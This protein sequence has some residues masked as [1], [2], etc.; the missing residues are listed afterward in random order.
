MRE[1]VEKALDTVALGVEG[2]VR[3]ARSVD[4]RAGWDH[5]RGAGTFNRLDGG[6][7]VVPLVG[8]D[9]WR[10]KPCQQ[11]LGLRVVGCLTWRQDE[12]ERIAKTINSRVNVGGQPARRPTKSFRLLSPPFAP[13]AC[14]WARTRVESIITYSKSGSPDRARNTRSQTPAFDHR[15]YRWNTLFHAP[16][17]SGSSRQCAPV[18]A[19]QSTAST[20]FRLS[21]AVR[22]S[23][24][25]TSELQSPKDL[26]CRLLLEK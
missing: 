23:E 6:F 13:A 22:R 3:G 12:A 20:N 24:E 19:I 21:V 18:R 26:V 2:T 16:K 9:V 17:L 10:G 7:A 1:P 8:N 5:G 15:L 25:H 4:T 14:W 11:R